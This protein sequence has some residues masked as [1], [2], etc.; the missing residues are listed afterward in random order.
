MKTLNDLFENHLKD[1]YSTEEQILNIF[2]SMLNVTNDVMLNTA[3]NDHIEE[4]RIHKA[5][6]RL[7]CDELQIDFEGHSC[8]GFEGLISTAKNFIEEEN[9]Q[10]VLNAGLLAHVRSIE[11]YEIAAYDTAVHFA[12]EL[13]YVEIAEKLRKTLDEEYNADDKLTD[14]AGERLS[15]FTHFRKK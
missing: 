13:G 10:Q 14:I 2:P 7:I 11:H 5:R 6:V 8:Q 1:L 12:L 4:T 3:L 9:S 15:L